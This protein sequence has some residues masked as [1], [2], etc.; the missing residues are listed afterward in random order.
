MNKLLSCR[1]NIPT[2][3]YNIFLHIRS[4][5]LRSE[6]FEIMREYVGAKHNKA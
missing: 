5:P 3:E 1:Y 6:I 4:A 2:I